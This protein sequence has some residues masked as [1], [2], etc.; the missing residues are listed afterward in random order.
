MI[1]HVPGRGW[2]VK[3]EEGKKLSKDTMTKKEALRRLAQIEWFK[4]HPKK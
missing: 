3:S 2:E 4:H 1:V